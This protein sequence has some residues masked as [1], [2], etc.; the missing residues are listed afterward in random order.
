MSK[1]TFAKRL[2]RIEARH[3]DTAGSAVKIA[4]TRVATRMQG[5]V[6]TGET[7]S[8]GALSKAVKGAALMFA[9]MFAMRNS[10]TVQQWLQSSQTLAPVASL[11][12]AVLALVCVFV[13]I[14]FAFKLHRAVRRFRTQPERLPFAAGMLIGFVFGIGPDV[15]LADLISRFN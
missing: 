15:F 9:P 3:S 6:V 4:E 1:E 13:V 12:M 8:E 5:N 2:Q 7:R 11:V 14:V 10:E